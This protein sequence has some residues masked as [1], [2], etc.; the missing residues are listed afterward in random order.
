MHSLDQEQCQRDLK[1]KLLG[2]FEYYAHRYEI[3][4][5]VLAGLMEGCKAMGL[6]SGPL[7]IA[8]ALR[9]FFSRERPLERW[10]QGEKV[11]A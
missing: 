11:F 7:D 8:R 10:I 3:I 1:S 9:D 5:S 6:Q 4:I 2:S